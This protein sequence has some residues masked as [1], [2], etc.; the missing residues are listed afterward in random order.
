MRNATLANATSIAAGAAGL[1]HFPVHPDDAIFALAEECLAAARCRD[2]AQ[3][4]F[5]AAERL[6][7]PAPMPEALMKTAADADVRLFA[8]P[9]IGKPYEPEE[10]AAIRVMC[11]ATAK[12]DMSGRAL[13][14]Y[15][16]GTE[17][18]ELWAGWRDAAGAAEQQSG[19]AAVKGAY[20]DAMDRF[21][22][23]ASRLAAI[24]AETIE[25]VFAKTRA[26]IG[27]FPDDDAMVDAI[28]MNI[29][30]YG[31]DDDSVALSLARDLVRLVATNK[32]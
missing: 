29:R 24:P 15:L 21:D 18:L 10:I 17:I 5:T 25:G 1:P 7:R 22:D 19:F 14:A 30:S 31:A 6:H 20:A 28:R 2:K 11:R 12:S 8:G 16:R 27:V 32:N 3:D 4:A 9:G 13:Q 26:L 23:L